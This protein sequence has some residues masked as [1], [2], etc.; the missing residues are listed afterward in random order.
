M[1]TFIIRQSIDKHKMKSELTQ[2]SRPKWKKW[3]FYLKNLQNY[4]S[5]Q[6][7]LGKNHQEVD[8]KEKLNK[9]IYIAKNIICYSLLR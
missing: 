8:I 4:A 1:G 3:T 5:E 2:K 9:S 6:L 7:L